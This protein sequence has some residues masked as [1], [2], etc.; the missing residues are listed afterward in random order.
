MKRLLRFN[1][2]QFYTIENVLYNFAVENLI[3][4]IDEGIK[5]KVELNKRLSD[6]GNNNY[7]LFY[8][9]NKDGFEWIDIKDHFISFLIRLKK[10]DYVDI[11]PI[12]SVA[13]GKNEVKITFSPEDYCS[14][15]TLEEL[16]NK[17]LE[18]GKIQR[19]EFYIKQIK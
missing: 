19:I 16:I 12:G 1:E 18:L 11:K 5:I 8:L 2:G 17:D 9:D 3:Y 13:A 7:Y 6:S 14:F 10:L 4:L 15:F